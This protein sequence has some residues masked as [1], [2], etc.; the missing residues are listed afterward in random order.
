MNDRYTTALHDK[1]TGKFKIV[2]VLKIDFEIQ[3]FYQN[4]IPCFHLRYA[5]NADFY[6][7]NE[8]PKY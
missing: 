4:L 6:V 8:I 1:V 2:S 5:R 3:H 7:N